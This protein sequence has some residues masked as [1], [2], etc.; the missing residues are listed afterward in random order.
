MIVRNAQGEVLLVRHSYGPPGWYILG[1]GLGKSEDPEAGALREMREEVGCEAQDF[2]L[3]GVLEDTI[4]G[5]PHTAY[6]FHCTTTDEPRP[7]RR[8]I[9]EARY[10]ALDELP[11]DLTQMGQERLAFYCQNG[12]AQAEDQARA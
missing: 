3:C 2:N 9:V 8:E 1:G 12:E 7:D 6:I 5:C 4:S 10:F 11:P